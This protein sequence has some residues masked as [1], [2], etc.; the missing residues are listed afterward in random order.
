MPLYTFTV[1]FDGSTH[2]AQ[3]SGSNPRGCL[4]ALLSSMP[5]TFLK[6]LSPGQLREFKESFIRAAPSE[7]EG[8]KHAWRFSFDFSGHGVVV[9]AVDTKR[10]T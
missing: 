5:K 2:M 6:D 3:L 8:L 7:I 9:Y 4:V 10:K 1:Q